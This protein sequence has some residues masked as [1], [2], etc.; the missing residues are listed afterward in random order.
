[1]RGNKKRVLAFLLAMFMVGS[2]MGNASLTVAASPNTTG[3]ETEGVT[4]TPEESISTETEDTSAVSGE[5][6]EK[7]PSSEELS[8]EEMAGEELSEEETAPAQT[9]AESEETELETTESETEAVGDSIVETEMDTVTETATE[10]ETVAEVTM[11][12]TPA[13]TE[14]FA[15]VADGEDTDPYYGEVFEHMSG[16]SLSI[17]GDKMST[18]SDA[19]LME[20][21]NYR[22]AEGRKFESVSVSYP[23]VENN[24]QGKV[25]KDIWNGLYGLL[26]GEHADLMFDF[27][28]E[29]DAEG[30]WFNIS[31]SWICYKPATTDKDVVFDVKWNTGEPKAGMEL[32]FANTT[33]PADDVEMQLYFERSCSVFETVKAAFADGP[34]AILYQNGKIVMD[35]S[36]QLSHDP[37]SRVD[38]KIKDINDLTKDAVYLLNAKE[39]T[40]IVSKD[41]NGGKYMISIDHAQK[42]GT[43]YTDDELVEMLQWNLETYG[44]IF[45]TI[46]YNDTLEPEANSRVISGKVANATRSIMTT[47]TTGM[48]GHSIGYYTRSDSGSNIFDVYMHQPEENFAPQEDATLSYNLTV[49]G[50][51][52]K[53]SFN[54]PEYKVKQ[55]QMRMTFKKGSE[56]ANA[57]ENLFGVNVYNKHLWIGQQGV[58]YDSDNNGVMLTFLDVKDLERNKEYQ[59]TE[60]QSGTIEEL[61]Y[62]RTEGRS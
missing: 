15:D 26:E 14:V 33:F 30:S 18:F 21:I 42:D 52:A 2:T 45:T 49:S 59:I 40:G 22:K 13:E 61:W 32:T 19:A 24:P 46:H 1:M 54:A 53:F 3:I 8:S 37:G 5:H 38:L 28:E 39:Y 27:T 55:L 11:E 31:R 9:E 56:K 43:L 20:I 57:L 12:E 62:K 51:E 34:Q 17:N 6:T 41:M 25:S 36:Y 4:E 16:D 7:I 23:Y 10:A 35:C 29:P 48:S 44:K 50:Q 47:E 58:L 60:G